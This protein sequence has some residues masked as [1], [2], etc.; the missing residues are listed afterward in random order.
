MKDS[1]MSS[2]DAETVEQIIER[3]KRERD[4]ARADLHLLKRAVSPSRAGVVPWEG[5]PDITYFVGVALRMRER[6]TKVE[7]AKAAGLQ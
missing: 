6:E 2:P 3:L 4:E 5:M 1:I 7:I